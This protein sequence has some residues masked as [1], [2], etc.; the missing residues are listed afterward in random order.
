MEYKV[1]LSD[2]F[3]SDLQEIVEY[4]AEVSGSETSSRIGNELLDCALEAGKK[5][6]VGQPVKQ[7]PGVRKVLRYHYL[8]YYDVNEPHKTVEV[9]RAWHGARDP[10]TLRL[11]I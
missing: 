6:F 11:G 1:I 5:P 3:L 7:R 8:I 9:L 2:L 10:K 4:L